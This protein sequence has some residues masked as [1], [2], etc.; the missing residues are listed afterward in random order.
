M[1]KVSTAENSLS[2][3]RNKFS[4]SLLNV[5][6]C[7][8]LSESK[9]SMTLKTSVPSRKIPSRCLLCF[10]KCN[11]QKKKQT[12]TNF[13]SL[14]LCNQNSEKLQRK[15]AADGLFK[16]LASALYS[17]S[18][19]TLFKRN[20]SGWKLVMSLYFKSSA[21]FWKALWLTKRKIL[22]RRPSIYL[23]ILCSLPWSRKQSMIQI[24]LWL[25]SSPS[26]SWESYSKRQKSIGAA[27]STLI[28]IF[29]LC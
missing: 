3:I 27:C 6:P 2:A 10:R 25:L 11:P 12:Y 13:I 7:S 17:L 24:C 22:T 8:R 18:F 4:T 23:F 1:T 19:A 26:F 9:R 20:T 5:W 15:N 16:I 28:L 21:A 29:S 14:V